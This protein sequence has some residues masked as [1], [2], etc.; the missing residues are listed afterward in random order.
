[1][2]HGWTVVPTLVV[3]GLG[4]SQFTER[5][6]GAE[7]LDDRLGI[8]TA[9]IFLMTRSDIQS[10]LKIDPKLAAACRHVAASLRHK[11][12]ALKGAKLPA[13]VAAR[14]AI[15]EEM[16]QW[17][18]TNLKPDQLDRLD[19]IDLQWEGP[20]AILSR[21]FYEESLSLTRVQREKLMSCLTEAKSHRAGGTW[22]YEDHRELTGKA[23]AILSEKQRHLWVRILGEPCQFQIG[24]K[25]AP[26]APRVSSAPPP[27]AR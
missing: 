4:L 12:S 10:D 22:T 25:E 24:N 11:A 27:Q 3:L 20:A 7:P 17:L 5:A 6:R 1:M 8:R 21:P 15:D 2:R 9:P 13:M 19:Q 26:A 14:R 16:S 18:I 23:L